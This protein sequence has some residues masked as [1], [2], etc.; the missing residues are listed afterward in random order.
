M[1]LAID[2][3]NLSKS[4]G[5]FPA[6][7]SLTL[8]IQ[9]GELLALL[10]PNGAGKTTAIECIIGLR[11]PDSGAIHLCGI[12][13]LTHPSDA[14]QILGA[15]LQSTA[16]HDKITPRQA[17]TFFASFYKKSARAADLLTQF[18]LTE[19][20]DATFDSLSGGTRQRLALALALINQPQI[21]FLDEPTAGLDPQSRR[22]LHSHIQTLRARG[23]TIL[24]STHYIHEAHHLAS[25]IALLSRGTIIATDTPANLIANSASLPIV[26]L[27]T[28]QP[29]TQQEL[30]ILP[31]I[32][33]AT[34]HD[35]AW[36][37]A[38]HSPTTTIQSLIHLLDQ[39]NITLQDLQIHH[40]TLEDV[41]LQL[42][43]TTLNTQEPENT[44]I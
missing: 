34:R 10:G 11:R 16:L 1:P 43:G 35:T 40:P 41:F 8:Q 19:K 26:Q 25:R 36:H 29:L 23:I 20:A 6:L 37:L 27:K 22:D 21:L 2:I 5:T 32:S 44:N 3:Q 12:N 13:A 39:K 7:H 31:N 14:K 30:A 33:S 18:N 38:T 42:T 9:P 28:A 4:Y 15:Q 24:L 17:L